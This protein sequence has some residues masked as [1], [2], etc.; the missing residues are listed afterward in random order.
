MGN[1]Q[2]IFTKILL[3]SRD[4]LPTETTVQ[5]TLLYQR[6]RVWIYPSRNLTLYQIPDRLILGILVEKPA[7]RRNLQSKI[8]MKVLDMNAFSVF[9]KALRSLPNISGKNVVVTCNMSLDN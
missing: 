6:R 7:V 4:Y 1:I 8:R 3:T 5:L 2:R 9:E